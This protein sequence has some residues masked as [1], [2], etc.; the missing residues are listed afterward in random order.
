MVAGVSGKPVASLSP[1]F[2]DGRA[3]RYGAGIDAGPWAFRGISAAAA[4]GDPTAAAALPRLLS[5]W[6]A[7]PEHWSF[8]V[9]ADWSYAVPAA[10]AIVG[11]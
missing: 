1:Y 7:K 4:L 10:R 6:G 9:N 2:A 3:V 5:K 8:L 11:E